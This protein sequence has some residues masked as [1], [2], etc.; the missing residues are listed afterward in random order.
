VSDNKRLIEEYLPVREISEI[1]AREKKHPEHPVALIHYW[2]ARR[3][4]TACRAAIYAA[5]VEAPNTAGERRQAAKF[6]TDLASFNVA[7]Q[8]VR[9]ASAQILAAHGGSPPRVLD[10]FAGGGA[11]PL[12]AARLGCVT[13]AVEYNPV[14]HIVELCTLVF[15]QRFG[16]TL[17]DDVQRV[18]NRVL[19]RLHKKVGD[20]YPSLKIRR[21]GVLRQ[22]L[23]MFGG[24][25]VPNEEVPVAYIWVR[26]VPCRKPGCGAVVPLVRQSWLRKRDGLISAVPRL[27][28]AGSELGWEIVLS[29][30]GGDRDDEQTGAGGAACLKCTTPATSA[31]VK[32]CGTAGRIGESL[33]AIVLLGPRSKLYV[34]GEVAGEQA[35][36]SIKDLAEELGLE[37]PSEQLRGKLCDQL[38]SYGYSR[39]ADLFTTRQLGVLLHLTALIRQAHAEMLADGMELERAAAVTTYLALAFGRLANS[40]T[41]FCRWQ[42]RDQITI[43]AIGDRQALKMVYDYSEINPFAETAGCLPFALESEV[44]SIRALSAVRQP[45]VVTRSNAEQLPF[46]DGS[47]DAVV[48]DPPY[49][50]SIFYADLSSF[51]YVWLRRIIGDLYP[52]HFAGPYPPKKREA[53]AQPSEHGGS[54]EAANAHYER[55]MAQVFGEVRRVLKPGAPLVCVYAHKTTAGW[56]SLIRTLVP[57]GITVT[58]AWPLQTEAKGR[59]NAIGASTLSDSIFLV[60]RRRESSSTGQ[61]ETEVVPELHQIASERVQT[62]WELGISGADLVIS[63]VGAGLRAFTRHARVEYANG[64]EVAA[65]RFLAEVET[66]V[67]DAILEKLSKLV[68]ANG[69]RHSLAGVDAATRFYILWR[70][71]YR[72]AEL[73]SGEAIVFANGTHVELDGSHGLSS[74]TKALLEK[75]KNKYRL[76]E[77]SDR[78]GD[79]RLGMP[80]E[81]GLPAPIIDALHRTLW[82]MEHHPKRVAEFIREAHPNLDQM[83]LVAQALLGPALKG[84]ELGDVSPTA[85]LAALAKL[86][87]NW[88]SVV[89]DFSGGP[90]FRAA[91]RS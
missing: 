12:E 40:F 74:G 8:T 10:V 28:H 31:Y 65:E 53:V 76:L 68:G 63:S 2:P 86:T 75:T 59:T 37:L 15:P 19:D 45:T 91:T 47:F 25:D 16:A 13:H 60:A 41:R 49:Y 27:R 36:I 43:A 80:S 35:R 79:L 22:Q 85:E 9:A 4:P 29:E 56:A 24:D 21:N 14:A 62:L 55:L 51:F 7:P 5:L 72:S 33:A 67:L 11:I 30:S 38:P 84:G 78:G 52:E 71:T 42:N 48:T 23:Q 32:E 90:L 39:F 26:T 77:Y 6:V 1:A 54:D 58:E 57:A 64:E 88:K 66:V 17:A 61:F 83:R 3:P 20:W 81:D 18:G 73:E 69:G 44:H 87:A 82:L 46:D 70:Y 89:E 50:D 34:G